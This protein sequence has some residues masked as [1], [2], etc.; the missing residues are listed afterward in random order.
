LFIRK[1]E[2]DVCF[3]QETKKVAYED[4]TL[5]GLW[6]H[7]EVGWVAQEAVG[8]S[9][10]MLIMWNNSSLKLLSTFSGNGYL[11]I[12][13]ER[14]GNILFLVNIY[15]PCSLAG[16]K[17][18]WED[19]LAFK[20]QNGDG[21]W[22]VGGDFN[23][24]LLSSERKGSGGDSRQGE[25]ILFNHFVE[26]MELIDVPV[27]GKK[28]SWFSADGKSM[29]RIDRFLLSDGFISVQGISGQWIG[30]RDIS[31][32]CPIWLMSETLNWGPKPFRV[33]NGWMEHPDFFSFVEKAWKNFDVQGRKAFIL[34]E[35]FKMLKAFLRKWNREVYGI[36]DLNI[37]QTVKELN[38]IEG[39]LGVDGVDLESTRRD[40]LVKD[41]W[42]QLHFKESLL[43]QKSRLRWV[44]EGDSNSRYF[45]ES[46]KSRRRKNQLI[47]LK[48]GDRWIQGV[49]E[50]KGFVKN[51]YEDNFR[52]RWED[53]P[54]L[55]GLTFRSL[56]MEDNMELTA[57]F[58]CDEVREAIWSS[59]GN[60]CP[61]PDGFNFNFLKA[62]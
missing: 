9:G 26:D 25:R 42:R 15:S 29:S 32:H 23:A 20:N 12:K 30:D 45:H 24:V 62:C 51:F 33:L 47:A 8:R 46:I 44:K 3:L 38:D 5:H 36:L 55:N 52:E 49:P 17:K 27:M 39:M 21:E 48:D 34:K 28:F 4:Y 54:N 61:G 22:C 14:E 41:F 37:D 16:K 31:D 11:G 18:L 10:G 7:K 6:G 40:G 56:T 19:L 35:K 1:G 57:S 58:T 2:F 53:R 59:D 13:V 60:K 43:K 50:V